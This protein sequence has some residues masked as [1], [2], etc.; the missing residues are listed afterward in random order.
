MGALINGREYIFAPNTYL[1][2]LLMPRLNVI[3]TKL[4]TV[5]KEQNTQFFS[6]QT[7]SF[8]LV[9]RQQVQSGLTPLAAEWYLQRGG[10]SGFS[11]YFDMPPID[12]EP[13]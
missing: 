3:E 12:D 9:C 13:W 2:D 5:I 7:C 6:T 11:S 1:N 10:F 4:D 8:Q